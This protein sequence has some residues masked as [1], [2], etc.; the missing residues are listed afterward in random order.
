MSCPSVA[1]LLAFY[2]YWLHSPRIQVEQSQQT[3]CRWLWQQ[4]AGWAASQKCL[5]QRPLLPQCWLAA[6]GCGARPHDSSAASLLV[7]TAAGKLSPPAQTVY[8]YQH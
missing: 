8:G 5:V 6:V 2:V 3:D 4:A 7:S 1:L